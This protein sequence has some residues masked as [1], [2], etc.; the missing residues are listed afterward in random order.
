MSSDDRYQEWNR[1]RTALAGLIE[2][3]GEVAAVVDAHVAAEL[4]AARA[5][6]L[7][8]SFRIM[9]IGVFD[10]GKSTLINAMLGEELLP[11]GYNPWT[12]FTTVL[13]WGEARQARLYQLEE[14]GAERPKPDVVSIDEYQRLVQL[15]LGADGLS[16][17]TSAY[18]RAVVS[19][20]VPLLA[21]GVELIDSAGVDEDL[22]REEITLGFLTKTDAIIFVTK[23][24]GGFSAQERGKYLSQI[25]GL[26][27]ADIFVVV[28]RFD[29]IDN[30]GERERVR[31][32]ALGLAAEFTT[33]PARRVFFT[34]ALDAL[35]ARTGLTGAQNLQS[36]G[37]PELEQ[38]IADFCQ[39]DR[40]RVKLGKPAKLLELDILSLQDR[41][42][43][44]RG[45]LSRDADELTA[46]FQAQAP[47]RENLALRRKAIKA[48]MQNWVT[49]TGQEI[50]QAAE[51]FYRAQAA[52]VAGWA[53]GLDRTERIKVLTLHPKDNLNKVAK[54]ISEGLARR[55]R[56]DFMENFLGGTFEA[57]AGQRESDLKLRLGPALKEYVASVRALRSELQ[58]PGITAQSDVI[59][60]AS[61]VD[62]V[63][64]AIL[65]VALP[66]LPGFVGAQFGTKEMLMAA[67]PVVVAAVAAH[68]A[69]FAFPPAA[70]A[71]IIS[72]AVASGGI[73]RGRIEKKVSSKISET[74]A[75]KLRA[76][77]PALGRE[78]ANAVKPK[79]SALQAELD[80]ALEEAEQAMKQDVEQ[81][82]T[83]LRGDQA[84]VKERQQALEDAEKTL[85]RLGRDLSDFTGG[86]YGTGS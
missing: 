31:S 85:N 8:D 32:R 62:R 82:L 48:E 37:V 21:N 27:H 7:A 35:K 34:S 18:G 30:P 12:A 55:Q 22:D 2:S 81:V 78:F 9:L 52:Q 41:I 5:Q 43:D 50:G 24:V 68:F 56:D 57:L 49:E 58:S 67:G 42:R 53:E 61:A 23:A 15:E 47:A 79:L 77:A 63:M 76:S 60:Q 4:A 73:A 33:D 38:A 51:D 36:S 17:R 86:L 1:Q 14:S 46:A 84:E 64:S 54:E 72:G 10:A 74:Y 16:R 66:G 69:A 71:I 19:V 83:R 44:Q 25:R 26:G 39:H 59:K 3:V 80:D 11:R 45:M 70:I 6:L 13:E 75:D 29:D 28:N 20:P 40:R 65:G